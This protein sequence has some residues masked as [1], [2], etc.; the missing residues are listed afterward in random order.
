M[1]AALHEQD[2]LCRTFG[3]CLAGGRIDRMVGDMVDQGIPD[4][5]KLFTYVRYNADLSRE[6]LIK[7]GC[8]DIKP[9]H[10]QQMDSVKHIAEMRRVGEAA[11]NRVA[12]P[13]DPTDPHA[14]GPRREHFAK[15]PA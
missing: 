3:D 10:V 7:L 12:D 11:A 1:A 4:V 8:P 9:E 6:G 15:F 2:F 5:P 13:Q 14:E